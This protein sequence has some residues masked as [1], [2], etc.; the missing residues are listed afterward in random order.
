MDNFKKQGEEELKRALLMMKYDNRKTLTEN[1]DKVKLMSEEIPAYPAP[2]PDPIVPASNDRSNSGVKTAQEYAENSSE[3]IDT[4]LG[5]KQ[6]PQGFSE[7]SFDAVRN[8]VSSDE[9]LVDALD[10]GSSFGFQMVG[11]SMSD[12][13]MGLVTQFINGAKGRCFKNPYDNLYYPK[14]EGMRYVYNVDEDGETLYGEIADPPGYNTASVTFWSQKTTTEMVKR[15]Q[16]WLDVMDE[17]QAN[18]DDEGKPTQTSTQQP[19]PEPTQT[20]KPKTNPYR[21]IKLRKIYDDSQIER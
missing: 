6:I 20:P 12:E 1:L 16:E 21:D 5:L 2:K 4:S 19:T 15:Y 3:T 9:G 17:T 7:D 8:E 18:V 10:S 13:D 11:V 14:I